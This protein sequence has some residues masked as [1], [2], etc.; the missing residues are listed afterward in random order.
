VKYNLFQIKKCNLNLFHKKGSAF[1]QTTVFERP[2]LT[3]QEAANLI[4]VSAP[5]MYEITERADFSAL[6][7][8]GRKKL[9]L[10]EK[11]LT[12]LE[13]QTER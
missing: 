5:T 11:F 2:T 10:R 8:V 9:I 13:L 12:W 3:V 1:M 4:G 6:I 7:R